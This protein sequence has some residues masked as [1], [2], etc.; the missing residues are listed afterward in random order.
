VKRRQLAGLTSAIV[1]AIASPSAANDSAAELAAGGLVLV[2]TDAIALQRED[3]ALSPLEVRVRYEMRNDTGQPVTLRVAFPMPEVPS[4]SPDGLTVG[5]GNYNNI[6]MKTP[7]EPNFMGFRVWANDR[8]L[9]PE[10]EIRAELPD[11]RDIAPALRDIGGLKLVMQPGLFDQS[12]KKKL[13]PETRRKLAAL[14]AFEQL[15]ATTWRL[16]WTTHVTFHWQ[17]TFAP[18]VT[19]VEHTY[20]PVLGF[21]FIVVDGNQPLKGSGGE[22]PAR[23]FCIDQA[24]DAAIRDLYRRLNAGKTAADAQPLSSYTLG[25]IL[26]TANNWRGPIGTFHFTLEGGPVV[27]DE[28]PRGAVRVTSLCTDLPL[29]RTGAQRF[30]A[31]VRDYSP[32][33]DL[34][35]LYIAE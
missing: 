30:E 5:S 4:N 10:V 22:E 28:R 12:D 16:P 32:K 15:D 19:V 8:E 18:G 34:R 9:R 23:A 25:Y 29:A 2:K 26:R 1:L 7:S 13:D 21:R 6:A 31:T 27:F 14:G 3:L 33:Q 20:R 11:G 17:Q 24:T 35:V